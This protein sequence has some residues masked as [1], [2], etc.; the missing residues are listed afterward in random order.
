[1]SLDHIRVKNKLWLL[2]AIVL[3]GTLALQVFSAFQTKSYLLEGRKQ[4]I[5]FLVDN[6]VKLVEHFYSQRAQ[7][8]EEVAKRK[9]FDAVRAL[10]YDGTKGYFW[11]NDFNLKLLMHPIKPQKEGKDMTNVK[12]G[13]GQYHWRAMRDAVK[14]KSAGFVEYS[15][16][17]PQFDQPMAKISYVKSFEPWGWIIG[18]GVYVTDVEDRFWSKLIRSLLFFGLIGIVVCL[19]AWMI[20][21]NITMPLSAIVKQMK[22]AASGDLTN[23][24]VD[25][26]RRDELGVLNK[27]FDSMASTF[28]TMIE[29]S[30]EGAARIAQVAETSSVISEQTSKGMN[31]QYTETDL[32]AS[33]IEELEMTLREVASNTSDTNQLTEDTQEQIENSNNMMNNTVGA[34]NQVSDEVSKASG[35]VEKLEEDIKQIDSILDVIRN[36]SEQ[37]NLL[38]LNAAI[39]AARAGESGRGFAVVADEVRSLAQRTHESTEEIQSMTENLQSEAQKAVKAMKTSSDR[40]QSS[41]GYAEQTGENLQVAT[42]KVVAVTERV[43]HIAETVRQQEEVVQEVS[44]NVNS[45]REVARETSEGTST[46]AEN[47]EQLRVLTKE[48]HE[49]LAQFKV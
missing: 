13:D 8:G 12:D 29:H 20:A 46:L 25:T 18:T 9:A 32:L 40:V 14:G 38:A 4:E 35:V 23:I 39:E 15:Y 10:R 17:G 27:S 44:K 19:V 37:T 1:M 30:N 24:Q 21:R 7:L 26:S 6:T 22:R 47:G 48:T 42:D 43:G 41:V 31:Q 2:M 36:I 34:I 49:L 45:I 16:K 3:L 5:R 28:K 11:V 33:A